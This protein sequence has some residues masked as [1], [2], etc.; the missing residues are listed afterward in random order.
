MENGFLN[1]RMCENIILL[2]V[3]G[4]LGMKNL[5]KKLKRINVLH[6]HMDKQ[7]HGWTNE[8]TDGWMDGW[9][10]GWCVKTR[11]TVFHFIPHLCKNGYSQQ[12]TAYNRIRLQIS[13]KLSITKKPV[14]VLLFYWTFDIFNKHFPKQS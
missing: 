2:M 11:Y 9:M 4:N 3:N 14:N 1:G 6:T 10:D 12:I 8:W 7:M 5:W 13:L